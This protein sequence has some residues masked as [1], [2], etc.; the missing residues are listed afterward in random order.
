MSQGRL[1][2][3]TDDHSVDH[4]IRRVC[5]LAALRL[6][7]AHHARDHACMRMINPRLSAYMLLPTY[8][9]VACRCSFH[10]PGANKGCIKA[11]QMSQEGQRFSHRAYK[12]NTLKRF[13]APARE[14]ETLHCYLS[15]S[16]KVKD[17]EHLR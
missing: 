5:R 7:V 11:L 10:V 6:E 17:L 14:G 12:M 4:E 2:D 3:R 15:S 13:R 1:L 16:T 9:S 8:R